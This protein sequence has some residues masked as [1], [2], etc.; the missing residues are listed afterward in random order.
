MAGEDRALERLLESFLESNEPPAAD[1][2]QRQDAFAEKAPDPQKP[3][4]LQVAPSELVLWSGRVG[5]FNND[6]LIVTIRRVIFKRGSAWTILRLRDI[7]TVDVAHAQLLVTTRGI[8][9]KV[10]F[11]KKE[12]AN[13]VARI[14]FQNMLH[15]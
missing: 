5:L 7:D 3:P 4:E 13:E 10:D 14:I 1:S 2:S 8:T 11:R 12:I 6:I 15:Q 9:H